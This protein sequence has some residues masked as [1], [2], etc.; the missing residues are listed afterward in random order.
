MP[1][2]VQPGVGL[3]QRRGVHRVQPPRSLGPDLGESVLPQDL[4]C[5]D[6]AGWVIPN[7]AP[8]HVCD[9]AGGPLA[10]GQQFQDPA[11]NRVTEDIERMHAA[12]IYSRA[13][14]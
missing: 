2:P 14:I 5:W 10:V 8:D 1:E 4:Q 3:L 6:T 13:L 11:S 12:H 9:L 7:S